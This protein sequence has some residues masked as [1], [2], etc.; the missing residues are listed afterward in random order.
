MPQGFCTRHNNNQSRSSA[1]AGSASLGSG[2]APSAPTRHRRGPRPPRALPAALRP[3]RPFTAA[4]GRMA[5]AGGAAL[6]AP[7]VLLY[8]GFSIGITFYNKWLMK[9]RGGGRAGRREGGM[10]GGWAAAAA[11]VVTAAVGPAEL[12]LPAARHPAAPPP[13]LRPLGDRPHPGALPLR[14]A[15]GR[16]LLGRLPAPGGPRRYGG[17]RGGGCRA[18]VAAS[19]AFSGVGAAGWAPG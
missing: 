13:H 5:A 18:A 11:A 15:A 16:A 6:T 3:R 17:A 12:P 8:Y 9:V 19:R 1:W 4:L 7:L 14:P 2:P 10:D